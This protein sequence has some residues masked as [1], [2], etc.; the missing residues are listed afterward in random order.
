MNRST[1]KKII[2]LGLVGL[3]LVISFAIAEDSIGPYNPVADVNRDGIVDIL[4]LVEVGE[5]YGSTGLSYQENKTVITVY[6]ETSPIENARV[7]V[8]PSSNWEYWFSETEEIGYTNVSGI[9]NFTLNPNKNYTLIAWNK[10][11][12][13]Y[14]NLTTSS[15]GEASASILL[16][17]S[18]KRFPH[19]WTII[20][21]HNRTS[22]E[23]YSE[24]V[25]LWASNIT[26][27]EFDVG[28]Y[29]IHFIGSITEEFLGWV[30]GGI[31]AHHSTVFTPHS[32][33]GVV[34]HDEYGIPLEAF[35]IFT[36]D[37]NG[38][39]NVVIHI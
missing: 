10:A 14:A 37:E 38:N 8:F 34:P 28:P 19:N 26:R 33:W 5:A 12:Y 21:L 3:F 24:Y 29:E 27:Y 35:S 6:N 22:G 9:V 23:L 20:T 31:L 17:D 15:F 18:L 2:A 16:S 39:A 30:S 11:N 36:P 4:D 13:N 25:D 7:A 32:I 1:F